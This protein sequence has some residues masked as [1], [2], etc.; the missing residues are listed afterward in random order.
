MQVFS[1]VPM[2]T[3]GADCLERLSASVATVARLGSEG[4][5]DTLVKA[6][7]VCDETVLGLPGTVSWSPPSDDCKSSLTFCPLAL[8]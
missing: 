5:T 8:P 4:K 6:F 1:D 7:H 3:S 2:P